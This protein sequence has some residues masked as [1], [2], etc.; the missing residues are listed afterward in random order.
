MFTAYLKQ[1]MVSYYHRQEAIWTELCYTIT[2]KKSL[3]DGE[4][5]IK[6][7]YPSFKVLILLQY[8]RYFLIS[9]KVYHSLS[10]ILTLS[11]YKNRNI[12]KKER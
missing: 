9:P 8:V 3:M 7:Q 5:V 1:Q 4:L 11:F 2:I 10:C 12:T 6:S